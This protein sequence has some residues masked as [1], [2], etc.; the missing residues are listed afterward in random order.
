MNETLFSGEFYVGD[1]RRK[2]GYRI[3]PFENLTVLQVY[4]KLRNSIVTNI[5]ITKCPKGLGLELPYE[6]GN[7]VREF[8]A[9]LDDYI[10]TCVDITENNINL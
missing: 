1:L 7:Y 2:D 6:H 10:L 9:K 5:V 8:K 4:N 3:E